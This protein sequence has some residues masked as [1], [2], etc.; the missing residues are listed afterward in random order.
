MATTTYLSNPA[1][2]TVDTVDLK[3][4]ASAVTLEL[5]YAS[6]DRTAFGD[7]G[8]QMTA[9]LQTVSGTITFYVDYGASGVEAT[10]NAALGDGTTDIVV[11]KDNAAISASNPEYTIT[12]T[13]YRQR[14]HHLHRGRAAGH[15]SVVRG[16]YVG[17]RHHAVATTRGDTDGQSRHR[18]AAPLHHH[19]RHLDSPDRRVQEHCSF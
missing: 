1:V 4:Q 19:K 3:D 17:A 15:G 6:L 2:L 13:M 11:K 7:T 10:I 5:G 16:R 12:D 14:A 9:G 8:S 18:Q